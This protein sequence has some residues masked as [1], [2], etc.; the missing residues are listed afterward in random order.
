[1]DWV[2]EF[3]PGNTR[4]SCSICGCPRRFP[5]NLTY[6]VDGLFRCE[7]CME[8]TAQ[9]RDAEIQAYR[10][11]YRENDGSIGLK[12]QAETSSFLSDARSA[13]D[14]LIPD[15]TPT[16]EFYDDFS[17]LPGAVGSSWSLVLTGTASVSALSGGGCRFDAG[18]G[19]CKASRSALALPLPQSGNFYMRIAFSSP[20]TDAPVAASPVQSFFFG[21]RDS[22]SQ[23]ILVGGVRNSLSRRTYVAMN[24][25]NT[26]A[27]ARSTRSLSTDEHIG[28]LWWKGD[29]GV[30]CRYDGQQ[31]ARFTH[32][33]SQNYTAFIGHE[34]N[35]SYRL[36][37]TECVFM[38]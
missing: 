36:D 4:A 26:F 38:V 20:D 30:F 32:T 18:T 28:E 12:P 16:T 29:G 1:M 6:C 35:A 13:R 22:V 7:K 9:E 14:Q 24:L 2:H 21:G 27:S 23:A 31:V 25:G 33:D 19:M 11:S 34:N 17:T 10:S 3:V 5:D 8:V 15:W 37:V